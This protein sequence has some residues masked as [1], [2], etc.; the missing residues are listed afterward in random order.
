M[1]YH[2]PN[3][4]LTVAN[5]KCVENIYCTNK[6]FFQKKKQEC[7][8]IS[9]QKAL[10]FSVLQKKCHILKFGTKAELYLI[11]LQQNTFESC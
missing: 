7:F 8:N 11:V 9:Q 5:I 4:I 10:Y 6:S 1:F 3:A 2:M